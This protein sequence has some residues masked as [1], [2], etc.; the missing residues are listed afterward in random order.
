MMVAVLSSRVVIH[1][2]DIDT[3]DRPGGLE[4]TV[5][6]EHDGAAVSQ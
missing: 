6:R 1:S 2:C 4:Q 5:I 3:M